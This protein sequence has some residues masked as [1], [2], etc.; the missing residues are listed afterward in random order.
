MAKTKKNRKN[1][2]VVLIIL[3]VIAIGISSYAVFRGIESYISTSSYFNLKTLTVE[4]IEDERYI[5]VMKEGLIGTNIFRIDTGKLSA[6]IRAKFPTFN[7]VTVT[8]VLP[9]ELRIDAKQRVPIAVLVRDAVYL[10]DADGVAVSSVGLSG[11]VNLPVIV[12][13]ENSIS[14]IKL[15]LSYKH[16]SFRRALSL[17]KALQQNK[18]K[19]QAGVQGNNKFSPAKIDVSNRDDLSFYLGD[20]VQVKVGSRDFNSK[21]RLLAAILKNMG[22]DVDN[23]KYIDLRSKEPAIAMKKESI[24]P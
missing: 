15:G 23:I 16:D 8:R 21:I 4:G 6:R 22:S 17:A 2:L 1:F 20:S 5:D 18:V 10:F 14:N 7:S 12:G 9:S 11:A 13:V 19:I 24:K 3:P